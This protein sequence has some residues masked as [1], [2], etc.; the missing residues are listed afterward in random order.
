MESLGIASELHGRG[1]LAEDTEM[2]EQV[3]SAVNRSDHYVD[4]QGSEY[5][6]LADMEVKMQQMVA[7]ACHITDC[8]FPGQQDRSRR[9]H[10]EA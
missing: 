4:Y 9:K 5:T 7:A 3:A 6:N 1:Y 8:Y 10:A 2:R